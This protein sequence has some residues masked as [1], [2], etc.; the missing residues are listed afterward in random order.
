[1]QERVGWLLVFLTSVNQKKDVKIIVGLYIVSIQDYVLREEA[2]SGCCI[3]NIQHQS[4]QWLWSSSS[5]FGRQDGGSE[6]V[7][8]F[9]LFMFMLNLIKIYWVRGCVAIIKDFLNCFTEEVTF[10]KDSRW[11]EQ[12]QWG[13]AMCVHC[14]ENLKMIILQNWFWLK[15]Y[16]IGWK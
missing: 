13:R 11:K 5:P 6:S 2:N 14:K 10:C 1:M 4:S 3:W 15:K 9:K 7:V 8:M 12:I 16:E